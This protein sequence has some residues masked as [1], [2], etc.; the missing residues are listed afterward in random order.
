MTSNQETK[1]PCTCH[2]GD[3]PPVPCAEKYALSDCQEYHGAYHPSTEDFK[4]N[5]IS[6]AIPI[7]EECLTRALSGQQEQQWLSVETD[8]PWTND[9]DDRGMVLWRDPRYSTNVGFWHSSMGYQYWMRIPLLSDQHVEKEGGVALREAPPAREQSEVQGF[10]AMRI[11]NQEINKAAEL[12]IAANYL[13]GL[14][15]CRAPLGH[16]VRMV[17]EK[18]VGGAYEMCDGRKFWID[19]PVAREIAKRITKTPYG[20]ETSQ[21]NTEDLEEKH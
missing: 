9:G 10:K 13:R 12:E 14:K 7:I 6:G 20:N 16:F 8:P 3:N 15:T 11:L 2:L 1:R 18:A 21:A 17:I 19:I 4:A 5:L